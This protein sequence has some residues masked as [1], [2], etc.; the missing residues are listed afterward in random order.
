MFEIDKPKE[1]AGVPFTARFAF[2][3]DFHRWEVTPP[4]C[5]YA[6]DRYTAPHCLRYAG[7]YY[8]N[9]YLEACRGWFETHVVRSRDL[10]HWEASPFNPVL[11][12]SDEDKKIANPALTETERLRI[13]KLGNVNNS[14]MDLCE[15]GGQVILLYCWGNQTDEGNLGKAV[16]RGT[17]DQFLK[18]WF[19]A[20]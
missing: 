17:L 9:F 7:G 11:R 5:V 2:S 4:E 16:Y 10:V 3:K 18:E 13:A 8:Y 12:P 6:K 14:D 1:Q 19:P 15:Y 20:K